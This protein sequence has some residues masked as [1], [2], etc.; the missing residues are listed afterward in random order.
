MNMKLIWVIFIGGLI[1]ITLNEERA[2]AY[3]FPFHI[4]FPEDTILNKTQSQEVI[5]TKYS[6]RSIQRA[7]KKLARIEKRYLKKYSGLNS[8]YKETL[9]EIDWRLSD[10]IFKYNIELQP[11]LLGGS[12]N[13]NIEQ[14]AQTI[15]R[16]WLDDFVAATENDKE[17]KA[18]IEEFKNWQARNNY[19]QGVIRNRKEQLKNSTSKY[20]SLKNLN[21]RFEKLNYYHLQETGY[22]LKELELRHKKLNPNAFS[23][24]INLENLKV[25]PINTPNVSTSLPNIK[26]TDLQKPEALLSG[27]PSSLPETQIA[28]PSS[29]IPIELNAQQELNGLQTNANVKEAVQKNIDELGPNAKAIIDERM[30][31]MQEQMGLLKLRS[32]TN[33]IADVPGIYNAADIPQFKVNPFKGKPIGER[34]TKRFSLQFNPAPVNKNIPDFT[35]PMGM[36]AGLQAGYM[37]SV[38]L[39]TGV[40]GNYKIGFGKDINHLGL[41]YPGYGYSGYVRYGLT[42]MWNALGELGE[43]VFT[44]PPNPLSLPT[45]QAGSREGG[46]VSALKKQTA[47]VGLCLMPPAMKNKSNIKNNLKNRVER[48]P[49]SIGMMIGYDFL[50]GEKLPRSSGVV[51]RSFVG[52]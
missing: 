27:L 2:F 8:E 21:R 30:G 41:S 1:S 25:K 9:C 19:L 38:R 5:S 33:S 28:T 15:K 24:Q 11:L 6:K 47:I 10:Y 51:V 3:S 36:D 17:I 12:N 26:V 32:W 23:K 46:N 49:A 39:E 22:V 35:V 20:N 45:G 7:N 34:F 31:K 43:N 40:S 50:A 42:R 29:T 16:K 44:S 18:T 13:I 48:K 4:T 52:F 37:V 14:P